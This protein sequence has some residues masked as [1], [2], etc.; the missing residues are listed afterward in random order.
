[1]LR[2]TTDAGYSRRGWRGSRW[3]D[4][5]KDPADLSFSDEFLRGWGIVGEQGGVVWVQ[6]FALEGEDPEI[7][8]AGRQVEGATVEIDGLGG[9]SWLILPYDTW[10]GEWLPDII[11]E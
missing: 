3:T 9:G 5:P 2:G 7:R 6:D 11:V 1:M 8:R 10:T 4:G